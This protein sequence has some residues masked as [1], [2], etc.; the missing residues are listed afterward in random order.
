MSSTKAFVL[1]ALASLAWPAAAHDM[2]PAKPQSQAI[3]F[4]GGHLHTVN[5][6][7]L[8]DTDL[9]INDGKISAIGQDLEAANAHVID[10][11]GKHLYPGLIALNTQIGLTEIALV[12]ATVDQGEIGNF[13]PELSSATA[14]N[15]DS[16]IIPTVRANGITHAQVV[17][18][19]DGLVGQSILV[20]MDAWNIE[21]AQLSTPGQLHLVWPT[22]R[23]P[24][25]TPEARE[26]QALA[27]KNSIKELEQNIEAS[28]RY[29]LAHQ[30]G[31]LT[32]KHQSYQAMVPL[33]ER[34]ASLFVHADKLS[35]IEAAGAL[36]RQYGLKLVIVGGY[37]AWRA[38]NNLNEIGAKVVYTHMLSMPMRKDDPI[39][40]PYRIPS[41]L[42]AANIPFAIGYTGDWDSRNLPFAAAQAI[43]HGLPA[44]VA[45]KAITE[46][47]A[48]IMGQKFMGTLEVGNHA[49]LIISSGDIFD[50]KSHNIDA[51]FID[52][53]AVDLNNR[54]KQLYQ[55]Y[56][57]R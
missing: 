35:A 1:L 52:G 21:D 44:D 11:S 49:N 56:L 26:Q 20:N 10:V 40:L 6:G 16:E 33:F 2:V 57:N 17:P 9:L 55:K 54:H 36:A 41:L 18:T 7:V 22:I 8:M 4:T 27:L 34:R 39:D 15:S 19:G 5:Q 25:A 29:F 13:N 48:L 38:A 32:D 43:A 3:L 31:T 12:R 14:F 50:P 45:L 37:D 30:A 23:W 51:L 28:Y 42:Q 53:R 47:P 46:N 24:A